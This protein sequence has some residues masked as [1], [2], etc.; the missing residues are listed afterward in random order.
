MNGNTNDLKIAF[1]KAFHLLFT[2]TM[3]RALVILTIFLI[4]NIAYNIY[5]KYGVLNSIK[6]VFSIFLGFFIK[7]YILV[8]LIGAFGEILK[9]LTTYNNFILLFSHIFAIL[10]WAYISCKIVLVDF[11]RLYTIFILT[12]C[13]II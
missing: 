12:G 9:H 2:D 5:K 13:P 3:I 8:I 1:D 7:T 6:Y 4:V 11:K 10:L